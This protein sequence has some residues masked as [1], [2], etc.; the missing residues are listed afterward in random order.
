MRARRS[1]RIVERTS[2]R[3]RISIGVA[4]LIRV[5]IQV[6]CGG[7]VVKHQRRQGDASFPSTRSKMKTMTKMRKKR[8]KTVETSSVAAVK[9]LVIKL[10][11]A[12][13]I[14]ILKL[15]AMT[16]K[17]TI[18][19]FK[20]SR[21]TVKTL[22]KRLWWLHKCL[23]NVWWC[24]RSKARRLKKFTQIILSNV[25]PWSLMTSTIRCTTLTSWW[26]TTQPI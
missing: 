15:F 10:K 14:Q 4:A 11:T 1:V 5:N 8:S 7:V 20:R 17:L 19:V 23:R 16:S 26:K 6:K 13:E 12:R 22:P 25:D 9:R 18:N 24:H 2:W 3:R 21:T